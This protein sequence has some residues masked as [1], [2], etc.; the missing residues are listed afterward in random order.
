MAPPPPSSPTR[1]STRPPSASASASSSSSSPSNRTRANGAAGASK[2]L[3][4]AQPA[5]VHF[6]G[7]A[8]HDSYQQR[9]FVHNNSSKPLRLQYTM[10]SKGVFRASFAGERRPIVPP[11]L[12][13]E[14]LVAFKPTAF[15]YY[16]DCIHVRCEEVAYAS[17]AD[18]AFTGA[19]L[20]PLHAYPV[21]NQ[22]E[23]PSR[24]DLG[25]VPLG[26]VARR[27]VDL[28]CSV[29]IAFEY[30]VQ[31]VKAHPS[32]SV[33]PLS[34]TIPANGAAQIEVEFRPLIY[35]TASTEIELHI[36]QL[37]FKPLRCVITGSSTSDATADAAAATP[38]A[39]AAAARPSSSPSPSRSPSSP[40][41][42]QP[43]KPSNP[44]SPTTNAS[45]RRRTAKSSDDSVERVGAVEIP[46]DLSTVTSVSFVLT[47][48]PGKLK[49]KDLKKAIEA[50]RAM[51]QQQK[52][53]QAKLSVADASSPEHED[54]DGDN[55]NRHEHSDV[56]RSP[57]ELAFAL[58]VREEAT[59]LQRATV[60]RP[61]REMF[62]LQELSEIKQ[63]ESEL[64]FQSHKTRVG[65]PLLSDEQLAA[66]HEIRKMNAL[67][68]ARREREAQR[69]DV[70]SRA[71]HLFT[72][73]SA[74]VPNPP[75]GSLPAHFRPAV[76]PDFKTYK[77]DLWNRR[78]RVVQRLV[79]AISLVVVRNRAQRRLERIKRW[80]GG[81]KTRA[82]VREKVALE[83]QAY[84]LRGGSGATASA[85]TT[86][87]PSTTKASGSKGP[88]PHQQ[89]QQ[90]VLR[91]FPLVEEKVHKRRDKLALPS[92]WELQ[93]DPFTFFSLREPPEA[94][95]MGHDALPLPPLPTYVPLEATRALRVG[96]LDECGPSGLRPS[97]DTTAPKLM[98]PPPEPSTLELLPRD[99]FLRPSAA[100]RPLLR[101]SMVRETQSEF[102]LRPLRVFRTPPRHWGHELDTGLGT[103]SLFSL[104]AGLL[105]LGDRFHPQ[106]Q[107]RLLDEQLVLL[108]STVPERKSEDKHA[109]LSTLY[110]GLWD[111]LQ[112]VRAA[113]LSAPEDVPYLSDSESDDDGGESARR[114]LP[115]WE[116]AVRLWE[117]DAGA[118]GGSGGDD[119]DDGVAYEPGELMARAQGVHCFERYRHLIQLEREYN[120]YREELLQRLPTV[121][122]WSFVVCRVCLCL[123][124]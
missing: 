28:R 116:D 54:D 27:H 87:T 20:V 103:R 99:V 40:S 50:N 77:N 52:D 108:P 106:T 44:Q 53:E 72:A 37:G 5:S 84:R 31:L 118:D 68:H 73:P 24:M 115:Q 93:G 107:R 55:N 15:Q 18:A 98:E 109:A 41:S 120:A 56:V 112:D 89:H 71:F 81:A 6:G 45:P 102:V 14:L 29:P 36:S 82:Q 33:F 67:E 19:C 80:L 90:L 62:F 113:L 34:G 117:E 121:R 94:L 70:E 86:T 124:R 60:A 2:R 10:P 61:S 65:E 96:A 101:V 43:S 66:L 21:V 104:R 49:P 35:A 17:N 11:G 48:Q 97:A 38:A 78:K 75:R 95:L 100:C 42:R 92:E 30:E 63:I 69:N 64:E 3:L 79:R 122:V 88:P 123:P 32:F 76:V 1:T 9:V 16:Y 59:A 119:D 110:C 23:F 83:W 85:T 4:F 22:V 39:A 91:G 47:Q 25:V 58:L 46:S 57:A 114:P 8:L 12:A 51:R 26:G 7:F 74:D 105:R 111:E 13:E